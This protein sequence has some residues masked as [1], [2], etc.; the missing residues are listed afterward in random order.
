MNVDRKDLMYGGFL[1]TVG[2][3]VITMSPF[4]R[5]NE[6]IKGHGDGVLTTA[7]LMIAIACLVVALHDDPMAK[8]GVLFWI[9]SP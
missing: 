6:W 1:I 8:A 5:L 7:L 3:V 4:D 2:V 9:V